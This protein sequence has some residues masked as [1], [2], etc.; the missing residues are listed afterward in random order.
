MF[1]LLAHYVRFPG[2]FDTKPFRYKLK[3][4]WYDIPKAST[5]TLKK[6]PGPKFNLKKIPGGGGVTRGKFG[7][8]CASEA[9]K[10]RS[11]LRQKLL[12]SPPCLSQETLLS[13]PDV[14]VLHTELSSFSH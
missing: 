7:K 14:F 4:I 11:C 3:S 6:I 8:R 13:D 2:S 1:L 9:F 5:K 12:I 10:H